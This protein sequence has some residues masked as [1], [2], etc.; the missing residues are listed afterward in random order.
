[1]RYRFKGFHT[2]FT[3]MDLH[4]DLFSGYES[5]L[6]SYIVIRMTW[7]WPQA[8]RSA[9]YW[10]SVI[11]GIIDRY[12]VQM[13]I[14]ADNVGDAMCRSSSSWN[15][16]SDRPHIMGIKI[17]CIWAE[18]CTLPSIT[19]NTN[20]HYTAFALHCISTIYSLRQHPFLCRM[21]CLL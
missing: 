5:M 1:M 4:Q 12:S 13:P 6:I 14:S 7:E 19:C 15:S 2:N 3:L 10:T 16:T 8:F 17:L 20:L 21:L 11:G 18:R 9:I